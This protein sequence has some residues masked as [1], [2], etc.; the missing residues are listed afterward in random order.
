MTK[1]ILGED[2]LPLFAEC[3]TLAANANC[4]IFDNGKD[5]VVY[6]KST[7]KNLF[8]GARKHLKG[9]KLMLKRM[10]PK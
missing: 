9:L 8:V 3:Q 10:Q 5:F 7:P 1:R 2:E 6:R 4:Y